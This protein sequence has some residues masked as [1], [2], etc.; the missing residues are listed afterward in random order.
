MMKL[1]EIQDAIRALPP[2][3]Q[4]VLRVWLDEAPLDLEVDSSQLETQLLKAVR[5]PHRALSK[6]ELETVAAR[7]AQEHRNRRPA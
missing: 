5:A 4:D 7:A 2:N 3:E 6:A 1:A